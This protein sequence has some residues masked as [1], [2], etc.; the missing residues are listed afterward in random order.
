V[1]AGMR[2]EDPTLA[3]CTIV[4]FIL[5]LAVLEDTYNPVCGIATEPN[6]SLRPWSDQ[7]PT[8]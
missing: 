7:A 4:P 2:R 8:V 5:D 1:K 6:P 3:F